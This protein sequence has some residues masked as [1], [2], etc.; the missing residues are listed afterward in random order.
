MQISHSV[1]AEI[2]QEGVLWRETQRDRRNLTNSVQLEENSDRGSG[3]VSGPRAHAAGDT[4]EGR[5][6]EFHGIPERKKQPAD[7]REIP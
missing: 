4:A 1:C 2:S 6:I 5:S 7:L 3:S